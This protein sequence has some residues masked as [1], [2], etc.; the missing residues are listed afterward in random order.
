MPFD[1][2]ERILVSNET[3]AQLLALH[4]AGYL[5]DSV[6]LHTLA[7]ALGWTACAEL[8][9][10]FARNPLASLV[11]PDGRVVCHDAVL[12]GID[13]ACPCPITVGDVVIAPRPPFLFWWYDRPVG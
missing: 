13:W 1:E 2:F 3:L 6:G 12:A 8:D 9:E 11:L 10:R 5:P 7:R 4:Q